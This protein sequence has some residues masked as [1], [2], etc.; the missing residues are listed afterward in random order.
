MCYVFKGQE[1]GFGKERGG[2]YLLETSHDYSAVAL[3]STNVVPGDSEKSA[4]QLAFLWHARLGHL[5]AKA[6]EM[7]HKDN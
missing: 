5:N 4:A 6:L 3:G 7:I 1:L 2:I